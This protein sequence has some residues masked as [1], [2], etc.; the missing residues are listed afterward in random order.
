MF[1]TKQQNN[2][3]SLIFIPANHSRGIKFG[4]S[5]LS[6]VVIIVLNKFATLEVDLN[7][8]FQLA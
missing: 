7:T 6:P 2:S 3:N 5:V 8:H 4:L 1:L